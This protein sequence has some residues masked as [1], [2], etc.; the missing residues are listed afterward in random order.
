FI[1]MDEYDGTNSK[2]IPLSAVQ[3]DKNYAMVIT[4]NGGLWR[5]LIGD[6]VKFTTRYPFR[7]RITGRTKH[8]INVFGEELIVDNAEQALKHACLQTK[9][10]ILEYTVAP[11]FMKGKN[12]G[13]HEWMIEFS[14]PPNDLNYFAELLDNTL[15][16]LNSD[17]EAKR[18]INITLNKPKI[19][20]ARVGLFYD[21]LK[22][23][24]KLGGQHKVPRLC[25]DRL[26]M[27]ELL[28]LN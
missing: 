17:Y 7:I 16:T 2:A 15:K 11:I 23:K 20:C 1:P 25:N 19:N 27:D 28:K 4:T 22:Q 24:G 14:T 9:S 3:L 18:Y 26:L 5:Y 10:T 12:K 21:W 13:A 6:T 8:F